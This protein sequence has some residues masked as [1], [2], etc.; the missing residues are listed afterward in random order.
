MYLLH[1]EKKLLFWNILSHG[2][3]RRAPSYGG[4]RTWVEDLPTGWLKQ[5]TFWHHS[6]EVTLKIHDKIRRSMVGGDNIY[7][8]IG[9][10]CPLFINKRCLLK[11]IHDEDVSRFLG[12]SMLDRRLADKHI[13]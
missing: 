12:V 3:Y 9:L 8:L 7:M 10:H 13:Q 5:I 4:V 6:Y 11:F 2:T 1:S